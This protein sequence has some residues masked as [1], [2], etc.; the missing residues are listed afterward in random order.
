M[1]TENDLINFI[2]NVFNGLNYGE[3]VSGLVLDIKKPF[4][5]II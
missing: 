2:T 3:K 4:T 1:S 5:Q